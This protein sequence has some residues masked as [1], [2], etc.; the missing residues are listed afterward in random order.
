MKGLALIFILLSVVIVFIIILIVVVNSDGNS[1]GHHIP[2]RPNMHRHHN[3][4][5]RD[6]MPEWERVLYMNPPNGLSGEQILNLSYFPDY[7]VIA[8]VSLRNL[9]KRNFPFNN[10]HIPFENTIYYDGNFAARLMSGAYSPN[11]F[12]ELMEEVGDG[13]H[14]KPGT[15]FVEKFAMS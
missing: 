10:F 15:S 13:I 8:D 12:Y 6:K 1:H 11:I 14:M 4:Y 3:I 5:T 2:Y 7:E 9:N